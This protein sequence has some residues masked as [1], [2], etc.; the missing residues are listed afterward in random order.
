MFTRT[1]LAAIAAGLALTVATAGPA[2]ALFV[3][4]NNGTGALVAPLAG[5]IL[6]VENLPQDLAPTTDYADDLVDPDGLVDSLLDR[7]VGTGN[8]LDELGAF[9]VGGIGYNVA[10]VLGTVLA[11]MA[12]ALTDVPLPI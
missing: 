3:G 12:G 1:R 6:N 2:M 4:T 11:L 7:T 5:V 10:G 9:L 8:V